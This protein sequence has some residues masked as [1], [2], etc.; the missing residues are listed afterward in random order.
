[1]TLGGPSQQ[2]AHLLRGVASARRNAH[3][4]AQDDPAAECST[5]N[6]CRPRKG[7]RYEGCG[8]WATARPVAGATPVKRET[9]HL[10]VS[11]TRATAI[12]SV[13]ALQHPN[14]SPYRAVGDRRRSSAQTSGTLVAI[15][16]LDPSTPLPRER[17]PSHSVGAWRSL[18]GPAR[19]HALL[20]PAPLRRSSL[21]GSSPKG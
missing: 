8:R 14:L 18:H 9:R 21:R 16:S 15:A 12:T 5:P 19:G 7:E 4:S 20:L 13:A 2:D 3:S 1:M 6:A 11:E 10:K 17:W